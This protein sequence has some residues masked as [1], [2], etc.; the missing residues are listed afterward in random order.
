M[1]YSTQ[2][3]DVDFFFG[4]Y[5][6]VFQLSLPCALRCS[7]AKLFLGVFLWCISITLNN[8]KNQIEYKL[9]HQ[10]I[11]PNFIL[12]ERKCKGKLS[13][14]ESQIVLLFFIATMVS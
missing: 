5:K 12:D 9:R 6:S 3:V 13:I 4:S 14:K 7:N 2:S 8:K 1:Q 11:K 10:A